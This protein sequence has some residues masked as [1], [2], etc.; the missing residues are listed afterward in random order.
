[1]N[2]LPCAREELLIPAVDAGGLE[3]MRITQVKTNIWIL[4]VKIKTKRDRIYLSTRRSPNEPR[5]FKR[6]EAAVSVGTRLF[7]AKQFT[8]VLP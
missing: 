5:Y 3:E 1:M 8:L 6:I 4:S 7:Q 2:K